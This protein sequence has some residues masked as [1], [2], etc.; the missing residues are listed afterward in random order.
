VI[1]KDSPAE[2]LEWYSIAASDLQLT[3]DSEINLPTLEEL[4]DA[5]SCLKSGKAVGIDSVPNELLS[6]C[7]SIR[8]HVLKFCQ[9]TYLGSPPTD[10]MISI[11]SPLFKKGD[12]NDLA[13]YRQIELMSCVAKL[14]NIILRK[15]LL[16]IV[17]GKLRVGQAGFLPGRSG[18]EHILTLRR[19]IECSTATRGTSLGMLFI[20]FSSAFDCIK[21]SK[22]I[23]AL[24]R[25][26]VPS[27]LIAAIMTLYSDHKCVVN[28]PSGHTSPYEVFS[29][30]LQG[31]TLAP[32]LFVICLNQVIERCMDGRQMLR[33][34][35]T[36]VSGCL[37]LCFADDLT[38][39]VYTNHPDDP[40]VCDQLQ[41][42]LQKLE[43]ESASFGLKINY[44]PGKTEYMLFGEQNRI[45]PIRSLSGVLVKKCDNYKYL[46]VMIGDAGT[47][48][49]RRISQAWSIYHG[50][51]RFWKS[52]YD[53]ST[54]ARVFNSTV[55]CVL[56]FGCEV[57]SYSLAETNRLCGAFMKLVRAMKGVRVH[58]YDT[59]VSNADL[60]G[61][62]FRPLLPEIIDRRLRFAAHCYRSSSRSLPVADFVLARPTSNRKKGRPRL[63]LP[64]MLVRDLGVREE[65]LPALLNNRSIFDD[66]AQQAF[67]S[68]EN[69]KPQMVRTEIPVGRG[70]PR[71]EHPSAAAIRMRKINAEKYRRSLVCRVCFNSACDIHCQACLGDEDSHTGRHC[72]ICCD[73]CSR[74]SSLLCLGINEPDSG[75]KNYCEDC[76]R[77]N[78]DLT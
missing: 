14:Y 74:W 19:L 4:K 13:N 59:R 45:N 78:L 37:E 36:W 50:L 46:G 66:A 29:G 1:V 48:I 10:W 8:P 33:P 67:A 35:S 9:Q 17:E 39:I 21:W 76:H 64:D 3:N 2:A 56:L 40:N 41:D 63:T 12:K 52:S 6:A 53:E 71:K 30:V 47:E 68:A 65:D 57:W 31:D 27:D 22:M 7:S 26:N 77:L 38:F 49:N 69:P 34:G 20:D 75:S 18:R 60:F 5:E 72:W 16:R 61:Q 58:S 70:R 73:G 32:L 51:K 25:L 54:K 44:G 28:T 55:R 42:F 62:H 23:G 11:C 15:R 43:T 24:E